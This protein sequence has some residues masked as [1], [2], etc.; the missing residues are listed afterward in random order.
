[1]LAYEKAMAA[2][3][4]DQSEGPRSRD[5]SR[6]LAPRHR[7]AERQD[8]RAVRS[9]PRQILNRVLPRGAGASGRR[10]LSDPQLRLSRAR[11]SWR[12]RPRAC[13][14]SS[15]PDRRTRCTCR[16]T[17]SRASACGTSRSPRTSRR[18]RRRTATSRACMPG[19]AAFDEL[20]AV[21]YLVYAYL[22]QGE[23]RRG[24]EARRARRRA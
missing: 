10:A 2:L 22:Q 4:R 7:P 19:A 23:D 3:E 12:C 5:L 20:H 9:R 15:L 6:A 13:T 16:R 14:R 11:A 18:P 17:S 21:D 8:L 24:A 1:M